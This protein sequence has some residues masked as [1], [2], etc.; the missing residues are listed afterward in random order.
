MRPEGW[1]ILVEYYEDSDIIE[2]MDGAIRE[3][4]LMQQRPAFEHREGNPHCVCTD[5][6]KARFSKHNEELL[7]EY[8]KSK[9]KKEWLR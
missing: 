6:A 9:A 8:L 7:E 1:D 5:C 2:A 3:V 4:L